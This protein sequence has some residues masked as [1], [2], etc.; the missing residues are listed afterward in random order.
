MSILVKEKKSETKPKAILL[1]LAVFVCLSLQNMRSQAISFSG[2]IIWKEKDLFLLDYDKCKVPYVRFTYKNNTNDSLYFYGNWAE[3]NAFL[4]FFYE[5]PMVSFSS[6]YLSPDPLELL[7]DSFPDWSENEYNVCI[8]VPQS[9]LY[10][11]NTRIHLDNMRKSKEHEI[12]QNLTAM[13][14]LQGEIN[15]MDS[16]L[17]YRFFHYPNRKVI[18]DAILN[19]YYEDKVNRMLT[20][21]AEERDLLQSERDSMDNNLYPKGVS[22][23]VYNLLEKDILNQCIFLTPF[24]EYTVEFDLTPFF[25][26]KGTYN[27]QTNKKKIRKF[28]TVWNKYIIPKSYSLEQEH[29]FESKYN[30]NYFKYKMPKKK[31]GYRLYSGKINGASVKIVFEKTR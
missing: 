2:E 16:T 6:D 25:L 27:F 28:V 23:R 3:T 20:E 7:M 8:D 9:Y 5:N 1:L 19:D 31:K 13:L 10:K 22:D 12:L 17:Q 24:A 26:L 14:E 21:F 30:N 11:V 4:Q 29:F 18:S 15:N